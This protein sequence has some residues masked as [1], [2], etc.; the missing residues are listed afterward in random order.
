M[1][2]VAILAHSL[3]HCCQPSLASPTASNHGLQKEVSS[4]RLHNERSTLRLIAREFRL[5][6]SF[7]GNIARESFLCMES[8][9][10]NHFSPF[11]R[12][13][14]LISSWTLIIL[15]WWRQ[16]DRENSVNRPARKTSVDLAVRF[17]SLGLQAPLLLYG[18]LL[19]TCTPPIAL[20]REPAQEQLD[21]MLATTNSIFDYA[22]PDLRLVL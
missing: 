10:E 1:H 12:M 20:H 4:S 15:K 16:Q 8:Q 22:C 14:E 13:R 9:P 6:S 21:H 7:S 3:L 19:R 5:L 2:Q 17:H 11:Y 18:L